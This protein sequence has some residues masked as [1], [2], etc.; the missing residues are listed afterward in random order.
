M[1][2]LIIFMLCA[3]FILTSTPKIRSQA[4]FNSLL[5][6]DKI[7]LHAEIY[8]LVNADDGFV[9][10]EKNSNMRSAPASLTKIVTAAVVL[11]RCTDLNEKVIVPAQV[12]AEIAGTNSSNA[13]LKAD[14]ELTVTDLLYCMLVPSANDA[15]SALAYHFGNGSTAAFVDM[16][17]EY[18]KKVGC[19]DTHFVNPHGLDEDDHYTTAAD[20]I[21]ILLY[22]KNNQPESYALFDKITTSRVYTVPETNKSKKRNLTSTVQITNSGIKDYY[23][24]YASG[25]KTGSTSQAGKCVVSKASKGGY[26]YYCIVM[27]APQYDIDKDRVEENCAF[28]DCKALFEHAFSNIEFKKVLSA[29]ESVGETKVELSRDTDYVNLVSPTDVSAFVPS[30]LNPTGLLVEIIPETLPEQL[31][32]PIKKGDKICMATIKYSGE[33]VATVELVAAEDV[34]RSTVLYIGA[35][36]KDMRGTNIFWIMIGL[37]A[38]ILATYF[39]VVLSIKSKQKKRRNLRVVNYRDVKNP[40]RYGKK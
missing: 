19:K 18:V 16:M 4:A 14:E 6:P 30:N 7:E 12:P 13:G 8:L 21:R 27:K 3:A 5:S 23:F 36:L 38:V 9:I 15:A 26:N 10:F 28:I 2:K 35:S 31:R 40:G 37:I 1:K 17:N 33:D 11:E 39:I 34:K 25:I 22:M 32:A 29:N 24:K 20:V